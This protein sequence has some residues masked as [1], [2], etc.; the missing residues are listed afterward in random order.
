MPSAWARSRSSLR[1]ICGVDGAVGREDA[2]ELRHVLGR[3]H[4][5]AR[6]GG[7]VGRRRAGQRCTTNSKPDELPSPMIGGRLK[8]K[9]L[10]DGDLGEGLV[11]LVAAHANTESVGVLALGERLQRRPRPA[12]GW[13][14]SRPSSRL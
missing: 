10:A 13:T 11:Q 12:R 1:L 3:D 7:E 5:A 9:T 6:D 2:G 14:G 8:A 4:Q